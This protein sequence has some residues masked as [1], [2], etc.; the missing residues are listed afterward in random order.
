MAVSIS[1]VMSKRWI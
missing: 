1:K